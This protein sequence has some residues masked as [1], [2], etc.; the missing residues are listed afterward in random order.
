VG[1]TQASAERYGVLYRDDV[2]DLRAARILPEK[3]LRQSGVAGLPANQMFDREPFT[4]TLAT[5]DGRLDFAYVMAHVTYG[6]TVAPRNAEVR[7][8]ASYCRDVA[9]EEPDVILCGDFNRNVGD[10]Q[11]LGWLMDQARL[12]DTT[13][14]DVPTVIRG[15]HTYDHILLNP[16]QTAEYRGEHGV[17]LWDQTLFPGN[18]RAATTAVS[19]HRPVWIELEV[20]AADDD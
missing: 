17:V 19:D 16:Q 18:E 11:S 9:R 8:L 14:P 4:V 3:P 1:N 15:T 5:D 20:P 2:F 13:S 12:I 7:L 10:P 6:E